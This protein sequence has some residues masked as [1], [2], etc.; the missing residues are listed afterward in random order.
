M[1]IPA[2]LWW[3][4]IGSLVWVLACD[5]LAAE[6]KLRRMLKGKRTKASHQVIAAMVVIVVWPWTTIKFFKR[7]SVV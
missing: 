6:V 3:L 2:T 1:L 4:L 5:G 7:R